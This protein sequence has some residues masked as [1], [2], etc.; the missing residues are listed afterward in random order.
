VILN[1]T[2]TGGTSRENDLEEKPVVND[3][4]RQSDRK[5][6]GQSKSLAKRVGGRGGRVGGYRGG[7]GEDREARG[8]CLSNVSNGADETRKG[9]PQKG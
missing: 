3:D 8:T 7:L 9:V 2:S 1:N 6:L 4:G 5:F